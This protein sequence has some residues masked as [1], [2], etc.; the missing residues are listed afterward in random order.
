MIG[1][2]A[3]R[4]TH[5][6]REHLVEVGRT[7]PQAWRMV[8]HYRA[9]RGTMYPDWPQACYLP[10]AAA[11]GI[12]AAQ[13]GVDITRLSTRHPERVPDAARLAALA[14]W[15]VTQG[16]YRFDPDLH[17]ALIDTP[18]TG[19]LPADVLMHLPEWCVYIETP[20]MS[21]AGSRVFGAWAHLDHDPSGRT[22][23]RFLL[24]GDSPA[25]VLLPIAIHVTGG[26]KEGL[27]AFIA[28]ATRQAEKIGVGA[29]LQAAEPFAG[30]ASAAFCRDVE[31]LVSLVL[32]LCTAAA[33]IS[34]GGHSER[35]H[36]PAPV[37]TRRHGLRVFPVDEPRQWDV[38]VRI[39]AAL[40]AAYQREGTGEGEPTGR[41]VRPHVRRAHW[42]TYRVGPGRTESRLRWLPPVAV[43]V[44]DAGKLPSVV[45]KVM[46]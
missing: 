1:A 16:I 32:Y 5:R 40:R 24:D 46:G 22:E 15:R 10:I 45:H 29:L 28:E 20:Q 34:R 39:G 30:G 27:D 25:C 19:D 23:L 11:A 4:A 8:D 43:N 7:Y 6:S 38:G 44:D 18:V 37:K 21:F 41:H 33:D 3:D 2:Q 42:H 35:P 13:A 9:G 17:G 26:L 14:A 31:P 12:V 36:N